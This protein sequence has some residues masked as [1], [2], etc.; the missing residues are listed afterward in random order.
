VQFAMS[1]NQEV[2]NVL[3]DVAEGLQAQGER[4]FRLMA[5]GRAAQR[6]ARMPEDVEVL[7]DMGRLDDIE[8]VGESIGAKVDEYLRSGKLGYLRQVRSQIPAAVKTLMVVPGIGAQRAWMIW[9]SLEVATLDD[10]AHAAIAH[11]LCRLP[12]IGETLE[13]RILAE[14]EHLSNARAEAHC[15]WIQLP[16]FGGP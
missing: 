7:C 3:F 6:I 1:R 2:A 15:R 11:R 16:L 9:Q 5:Y 13:T 10:L 14:L 12:G 4:G 8:G